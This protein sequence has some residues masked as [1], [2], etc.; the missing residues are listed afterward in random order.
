MRSSELRPHGPVSHVP[1]AACCSRLGYLP[2]GL[3]VALW[4]REH[5]LGIHSVCHADHFVVFIPRS[6]ERRR[7]MQVFLLLLLFL[8]VCVRGCRSFQGELCIGIVS[9]DGAQSACCV[10]SCEKGLS[11]RGVMFSSGPHRSVLGSDYNPS[12]SM[13][14]NLCKTLCPACSID[15]V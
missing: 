2:P 15:E 3:T 10:L 1:S 14:C 5:A 8:C 4:M 7:K 13:K 11:V 9:G 6:S 12:A